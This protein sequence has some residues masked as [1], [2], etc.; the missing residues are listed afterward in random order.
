MSKHLERK[1]RIYFECYEK[2]I[3]ADALELIKDSEIINGVL[4]LPKTRKPK[5][6]D[7]RNF[8]TKTE[9]EQK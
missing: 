1:I 5:F 4:I 3:D 2:T 6:K 7:I 9:S 8:N